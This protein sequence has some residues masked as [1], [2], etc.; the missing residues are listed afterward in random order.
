MIQKNMKYDMNYFKDD[1]FKQLFEQLKKKYISRGYCGGVIDIIPN[2]LEAEKLSGFLDKR[3][4]PNEKNKIKIDDIQKGLNNSKFEGLTVDELVLFMF[5][6]LKS[7]KEI[8]LE[9]NKYIDDILNIYKEKYNQ[10]TIFDNKDCLK[11]IKNLI[12]NDKKLL[13]NVLNSLINLPIN[14]NDI[15]HLSIFSSEITGDPH[16][17]DIDT[18]NSNVLIQFICIYL[19]IEYI[20]KRIEKK[21]ILN[22][23]GI[24]IEEVSNY[25]I[26]YNLSGNEMLDSFKN[27]LT[28]LTINLAN[29]RKINNIKAENNNL[30]II[31]N[32]SFLSKI[33]GKKVNYSILITSGNSNLVI[34]KLLEKMRNTNIYFNG[35]FDPEGLL[36]AQNFKNNYPNLKF[37]G[38][39]ESNYLNGISN[40][41]INNTRLKKLNNIFDKD[42]CVIKDLLISRKLASYQ[43]SNYEKILEELNQL[44]NHKID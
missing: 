21:K 42:L 15:K 25:V 23:V 37:I 34:Y 43:E 16:Y 11:K 26:T 14:N 39:N 24:L 7:N 17:F 40:N 19:D 29:I 3:I 18:H 28:P 35:D 1:R 30:L 44:F 31:E 4:K 13:E 8:Y 22:E 10:L 6:N 41:E 12:I 32:P 5:P 27:N 20:N 36:I 2:P 9:K 38:Y 33:I